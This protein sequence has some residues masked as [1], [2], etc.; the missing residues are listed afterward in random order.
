MSTVR[1]DEYKGSFDGAANMQWPLRPLTHK[2][3]MKWTVARQLSFR[4]AFFH[5][6]LHPT[7]HRPVCARELKML[8]TLEWA[9]NYTLYW[10]ILQSHL[11]SC[12]HRAPACDEMS[13]V[14]LSNTV[15]QRTMSAEL[16][17]KN[18]IDSMTTHADR[19]ATNEYNM[20]W[21]LWPEKKLNWLRVA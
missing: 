16:L 7:T 11:V 14:Y 12:T 15:G 9:L 5:R 6:A 4:Q 19:Y 8:S 13:Q 21:S 2:A 3:H 10:I 1:A 17:V 20:V 18:S